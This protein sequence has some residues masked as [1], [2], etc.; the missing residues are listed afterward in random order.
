MAR[1]VEFA[2]DAASAC[3][4]PLLEAFLAEDRAPLCRTERHGCVFAAR[5][6]GGL[7]FD[8]TIHRRTR[9]DPVSP[10]GLTGLAALGLV[11]ELLVGE[12]ELFAGCPNEFGSAVHTPQGLVLELHRSPPRAVARPDPDALLRFAPELLAVALTRQSLLGP[13]FVTRLQVERVFLDVL[14]D[15]F[16][17]NFTLEAAKGALNRLT[18]L[19]LDFSHA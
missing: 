8:A 17:L 7:G 2:S 15:V 18:F 12:E 13:A 11:L 1:D 14:D 9:C 6:T 10:L 5:G 4:L 16:L 19:N 3:E